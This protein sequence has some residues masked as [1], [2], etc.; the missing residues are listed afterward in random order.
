MGTL[1]ASGD[2]DITVASI[3]SITSRDRIDKFDPDT[4]KLLVVDE[5]HHI[6]APTYLQALEHFGI[7]GETKLPTPALVGFSATFSR[8]DGLALSKVIEEIVYHKYLFL[9]LGSHKECVLTSAE[10]TSR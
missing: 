8:F 10:T 2:A 6:V 7:Q 5:A 4:F 9:C 3:Q 1:H